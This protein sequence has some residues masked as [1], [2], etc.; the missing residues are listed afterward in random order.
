[1]VLWG[2]SNR[3]NSALN[4]CVKR[5]DEHSSYESSAVILL[6]WSIPRIRDWLSELWGNVH[7]FFILFVLPHSNLGSFLPLQTSYLLLKL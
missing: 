2:K 1:M 4:I 3:T 5:E 6:D 7:Q